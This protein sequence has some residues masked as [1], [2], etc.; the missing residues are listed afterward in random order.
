MCIRD[1][2]LVARLLDEGR[3]LASCPVTVTEIYAGMRLHEERTTRAFMQSLL[4][5][6]VTE[7][8][9]ERAGRLKMQYAGKGRSLS[10]QDVTIAAVCLAHD[11]T[12]VTGNVKDF[13]MP[14]LQI[15]AIPGRLSQR[16]VDRSS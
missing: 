13:P 2:L 8:I 7:E 10:L 15:Y 14:E 11:C 12:L 5:L 4:F 9:A 3:P 1:S 16:P 6:P